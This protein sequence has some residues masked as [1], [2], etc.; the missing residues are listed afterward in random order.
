[1]TPIVADSLHW[2]RTTREIWWRTEIVGNLRE[3]M[4]GRVGNPRGSGQS[5]FTEKSV[6]WMIPRG[7][8]SSLDFDSH[9]GAWY[10]QRRGT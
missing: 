1:M 2:T 6:S 7:A 4:W 10:G 3:L 5:G 9:A 8:S